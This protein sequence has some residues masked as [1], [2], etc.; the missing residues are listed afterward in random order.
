MAL[1]EHTPEFALL[2]YINRMLSR[3]QGKIKELWA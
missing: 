2:V 3:P 1:P